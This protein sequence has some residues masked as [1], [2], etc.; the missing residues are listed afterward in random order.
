MKNSIIVLTVIALYSCTNQRDDKQPFKP[1]LDTS[2]V[3]VVYKLG[4]WRLD[5]AF[6]VVKDTFMLSSID[7]SQ[8]A[9]KMEWKKD[10]VY[11]IPVVTDTA[12][13][14]VRWFAVPPLAA[15]E[16]KVRPIAN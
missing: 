4:E 6:R 8:G 12:S 5:S 14:Q 9:A 16:V 15:Q 3:Q 7:S 11:F 13:R 2:K 10:T 1:A